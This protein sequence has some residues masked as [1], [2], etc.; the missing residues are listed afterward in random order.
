M[1][2]NWKA[3]VAVGVLAL[4]GVLGTGATS[5]HA[6]VVGG[7]ARGTYPGY[8]YSPGGYVGGTYFSPGY[9]PNPGSASGRVGAGSYSYSGSTA[10][11][12][13]ARPKV[14]YYDPTTGRNNLAIP[15]AKPWLRPLQ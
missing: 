15:L 10:A 7:P 4:G 13:R 2:A 3:I 5:T 14:N 8:Y 1:Q 12:R 6:Q 9:Y 11:P